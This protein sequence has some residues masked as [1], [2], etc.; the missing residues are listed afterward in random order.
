MKITI[1][2]DTGGVFPLEI[3]A[4]LTVRD[5]QALVELET[6]I[7]QTELLLI[8][9]M[10]PLVELTKTVG[11]C[12]VEGGIIVA[13]RV[14]GGVTMNDPVTLPQP[15]RV[16]GRERRGR[17]NGRNCFFLP[18]PVLS[19]PPSLPPSLLSHLSPPL[20]LTISLSPSLTLS[21]SLPPLSLTVTLS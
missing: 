14:D 6:G 1:T 12:G 11:E 15:G 13:S 21:I 4:D 8:H 18:S 16:S 3:G 17:E 5:L 9:N 10:A 2:S 19:I 20:T 7:P